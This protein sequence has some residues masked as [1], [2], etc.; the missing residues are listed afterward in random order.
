[1]L[2]WAPAG[3]QW[4]Q[5]DLEPGEDA[6]L[7]SYNEAVWV[8]PRMTPAHLPRQVQGVSLQRDFV[9]L[10]PPA[11]KRVDKARVLTAHRLLASIVKRSSL[12]TIAYLYSVRL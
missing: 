6:S 1:M 5:A 11:Q 8:L 10:R 12:S 9:H 4:T 2:R 3:P 7:S